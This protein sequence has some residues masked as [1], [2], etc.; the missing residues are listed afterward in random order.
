MHLLF[1]SNYYPP[2]TV[3]GYELWCHD[4]AQEFARRGHQVS[5]VT[6]RARSDAHNT[7]NDSVY[8]V[9]NLEVTGGLSRTLV[10]LATRSARESETL[11]SLR[12]VVHDTQP[13]VALIW[14][15]WNVPRSVPALVEQLM[16]ERTAY[17]LCDYW[18]TLPS[19]YVQQLKA[20]ARRP[21]MRLVKKAVTGPFVSRLDAEPLSALRFRNPICCSEAVRRTLVR[22]GVE[23]SHAQV[24]FGGIK[25]TDF[26]GDRGADASNAG[27]FRLI[28]LGRLAP[29]K[30]VLAA[31]RAMDVLRHSR[32]RVTLDLV[33]SGESRYERELRRHV[34]AH[35]LSDR[36]RFAGSVAP[37]RVPAYLRQ[38]D[39][40]VFPSEWEEPFARTVLEAM[41]AGLPVI[42]TTTGGT[43]EVLIDGITGITFP[44]GDAAA[45]ADSIGRLAGNAPLTRRL[46]QNARARI[47][48]RFTLDRMADELESNLLALACEK[49]VLSRVRG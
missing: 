30:G 12:R 21:V 18:P 33:G 2:E 5:V 22:E 34:G 41:A 25:A 19:A 46:A 47:L 6:A 14:G 7:A 11:S 36:V 16:P 27:T 3:G 24:V 8:R 39:A 4:V 29:E 26:S 43:G 28:Y 32:V 10:E 44:P 45:L 42:G 9:I 37:S 20:V 15:M 13:D 38:Y 48:E 35:G 17:Y 31:V 49:P 1:V 23:I 40:L